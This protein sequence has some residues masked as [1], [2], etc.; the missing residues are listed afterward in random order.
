M[1]DGIFYTK[2]GDRFE[3]GANTGFMV[4]ALYKR[5]IYT[6]KFAYGVRLAYET[7][8]IKALYNEY[9]LIED[10]PSSVS[11]ETFKASVLFRNE[12]E[13]QFSLL[14]ITPYIE[15]SPL[16]NAFLHVGVM[17]QF[18]FD[19]HVSHNKKLAQESVTLG[20][21]RV[22][23]ISIDGENGQQATVEDGSVPDVASLQFAIAGGVGIDIP[24]SKKVVITPLYQ[25][26]IPLTTLSERG[27]SF[28]IRA[29]QLLLSITME[30]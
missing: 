27:Q 26:A 28:R 7:R 9:E 24:V 16:W 4:G 19:T 23:R 18:V 17:P 13:I 2:C 5:F 8:N 30:L 12:A 11:G 14:S 21:G 25:Y 22:E 15:W 10:I 3:Q 20:D 29:S 1:Q 6:S